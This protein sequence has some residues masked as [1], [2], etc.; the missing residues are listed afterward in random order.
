[1]KPVPAPDLSLLSPLA[2]ELAST[3]ARVSSDI[4]LVIDRDGVIVSVAQG[5][6]PL[7]PSCAA[8][9]GRPWAETASADSRRKLE[10]LLAEVGESGIGRRREINHPD[11]DG[12]AIPVA[13]SAIRLGEGG[14]VVAVGRD[15][16]A[17]AAIQQRFLDAQQELERAYWQRRQAQSRQRLL[18][19]VAHDAI[20][21]LDATSLRVLE[22][23]DRA[24]AMLGASGAGSALVG[25][26][27]AASR[28][29]VGELLESTRA[30]GRATEI[31][32]RLGDAT[33]PAD[34]AATPFRAGGDQRLLL[35]A[36]RDEPADETLLAL[37]AA[38]DDTALVVVDGASRVLCANAAFVLLV[39][40]SDESQIVGRPLVELL[41]DSAA[42][43]S[44][45]LTRAR[46]EG[47]VAREPMTLS[48]SEG[49][50]F[51]VCATLMAEGEQEC[52]GLAITTRPMGEHASAGT[53]KADLLLRRV[54]AIVA[55]LGAA[56]LAELLA[57]V[58]QAAERHLI[59]LALQRAHGLVP[60][61][62]SQLG[63]SEDD[64]ARRLQHLGLSDDGS[65]AI[66]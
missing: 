2:P 19:Q 53:L 43:W 38:A 44:V 39:H 15:L 37:A 62:A 59:A 18:Y 65:P 14:A 8:W 64:L 40:R 29:A 20:W 66:N 45:L 25:L 27:P 26:V 10:L 5:A 21:V 33:A 7:A 42:D 57:Q 54:E 24:L 28:P 41:G 23:N 50:A 61:A 11:G 4:A 58:E 13:W 30:T 49:A 34:L 22:A 55:R 60:A 9:V 3:I 32:A 36:R 6:A 48:G 31:H 56:P 52:V 35:R 17:V 12:G 16:R 51:M 46:Y 1:M 63:L 47:L